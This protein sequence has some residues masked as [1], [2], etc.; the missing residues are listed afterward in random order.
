M[1]AAAIEASARLEDKDAL[2]IAA[3]HLNDPNAMVRGYA[4]RAFGV[5]ASGTRSE[6]LTRMLDDDDPEVRAVSLRW[7][8]NHRSQIALKAA[9]VL[10]NDPNPAVRIAAILTFETVGSDRHCTYLERACLDVHPEVCQRARD[11]LTA[12]RSFV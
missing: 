1:R 7:L 12:L 5:L 3:R 11:A 2:P 10:I 8:T 6:E 9:M 4:V